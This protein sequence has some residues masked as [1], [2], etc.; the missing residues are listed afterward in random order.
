MSG[1][2]TAPSF[3]EAAADLTA[4]SRFLKNKNKISKAF[5]SNYAI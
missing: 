3:W 2:C 1:N 5:I 4:Q